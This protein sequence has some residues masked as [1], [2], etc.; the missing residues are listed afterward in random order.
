MPKCCKPVNVNVCCR[1]VITGEDPPPVEITSMASIRREDIKTTHEEADNILPQQMVHVAGQ[2]DRCVSVISDDTDV[3][4][5]L[6]YHYFKE[7]TKWPCHNGVP[8]SGK[9]NHRHK[10]TVNAS[11]PCFIRV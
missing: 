10:A 2:A 5:L 11:S 7:K 9:D 3:L 4:V 1:L 6:M 8:S